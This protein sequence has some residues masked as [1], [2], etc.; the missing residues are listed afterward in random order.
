MS[1]NQ[2][3]TPAVMDDVIKGYADGIR[4]KDITVIKRNGSYA[5]YEPDKIRRAIRQ[6]FKR[7]R[8]RYRAE[9][10]DKIDNEVKYYIA[11]NMEIYPTGSPT[12][13]GAYTI[14][15]EEIQDIVENV[16]MASSPNCAKEYILYRNHREQVRSW[17]DSKE[18]F[19]RKYKESTNTAN[20]TI[21]DNSNV[22]NKNIGILN[23]EIHKEDNIQISRRMVVRKLREIFPD[24]DAKQ[25]ERDLESHIIYKHDE[26][27][28]AGAVAPYCVALTM[29]PFL[30]GGIKGIGGLSAK[31]KNLDSY[32]GMLVNMIFA[33][34]AQ[35]AGACLYKD[36]RL[37]VRED[38]MLKSL[39]ISDIVSKFNTKYELHNSEGDWEVAM[40]N[41]NLE[42]W[43]DGKFVNISKVYRRKYD[44][45]IYRIH[46]YGGKV[47]TTSKDHRFKVRFRD[48]DFEVK[49]KD[50]KVND[51]LY[52]TDKI[53]YPIDKASKDYKDGQL[54][55]IIAGDGSININGIRVAVNYKETFISDWLDN[56]FHEYKGK[57]GILRDGHKC[58]QWEFNSREYAAWLAD[59]IF[60]G[61]DT[62]TKS[63]R[64][65]VFENASLEFLCGFLDGVLATDGSF[66]NNV[67]GL[68]LTNEKLI[69]QISEIVVRLGKYVSPIKYY[70]KSGSFKNARPAWKIN[71]SK[72][73][74]PYLDLT[75][76]RR[77][78]NHK[79]MNDTI[80]STY[81]YGGNA[82]KHSMGKD[83]AYCIGDYSKVPVRNLDAIKSIE[84]IDNDDNYV[85]EIETETHWY[86]AGDVLTHNCAVPEALLYFDYFARKEWGD[87]Y[88]LHTEDIVNPRS[89]HPRTIREQIHQHFQQVVYSI[90]QPAAARGLQSAFVNFSYYDK[91]FY[92]GM[93]GNFVFPDFTKPIWESFN[94]LQKDFMQWFNDER[95]KCILTFPVES[96]AMVYQDHEFLDPESADF[97]AEEYARGH[98]FFTYISDTVDSLSSCCRLK[99]KLQ[100]K[101]FNFTNG[102]MGLQT[103]SKSVIT[104]NLNRTI[105]DWARLNNRT[106]GASG[107]SKE[108]QESLIEYL[109]AIVDRIYKYHTAYNE[110]LW[111]MKDAHLLP[112][113]DAGF[114]DLNKQ[115]LTIGINGLNQAAEFLGY[116]CN[117]NEQ[118][119]QFCQLIF[120]AI[121]AKNKEAGKEKFN[122]HTL[123]FNTEQV[124]AE[125]LAIKNYNWDKEDDYWVPEDT[126]LYAS[127]IFKPNDPTTDIFEKLR[128]HGREYIGDYLDGGSAAH[129]NLEEHLTKDQ[130]KNIIKY[131]AEQGTNYFTFNIPMSECCDCGHIVNGPVDECPICHSHNIKYWV[132]IIGYLTAVT[133]WSA[134]RREEFK[135]RIF[136]GKNAGEY[137]TFEQK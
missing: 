84:V 77:S 55:G 58:Y 102:N 2:Q 86:S 18:E 17:V 21:D 38:G 132:R 126:N 105:Q 42:V 104:I 80:K 87:D 23:T 90:N 81:Y 107:L 92:E 110:L 75:S 12:P 99:N 62:Y 6:C 35:F 91:A 124:P 14:K 65:D 131:A 123:T 134:G 45:K 119:K 111:D 60:D 34:S 32:C 50:L 52:R 19:I 109:G 72:L 8:V 85:Y 120:G 47:I 39:K 27:S 106:A 112:V 125:S 67:H 7:C 5:N 16:L 73:I 127:Y 103:G 100:T 94:W 97:V 51:T 26:S 130:Y 37:I 40:V 135:S 36:Q 76:I 44:D 118:Y 43:E 59:N 29:Y 137:T 64:D 116:T 11:K 54:Y 56:Y 68:M 63:L 108:E 121:A 82:F 61:T 83:K 25:Y 69:K 115:Y 53:D 4:N 129:I 88:Y 114:I 46:T 95:K 48:R 24:F 9:L 136:H 15:V 30:D 41:G 89:Q 98:S 3:H 133:S 20:A 28:F 74:N 128:M 49:A 33:I 113:Y 101:E 78:S 66:Q 10:L 31:P 117:D 1:E 96:F 71:I 79:Y 70:E 93:F 122:G 22:T 57:P 13:M